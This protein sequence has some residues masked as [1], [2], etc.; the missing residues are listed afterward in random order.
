M[1]DFR[2]ESY[3]VRR[4]GNDVVYEDTQGVRVTGLALVRDEV[5]YARGRG[6]ARGHV[7]HCDRCGVPCH[8]D[9]LGCQS[10][11]MLCRD[12]CYDYDID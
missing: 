7:C 4:L 9:D 5:R 1:S 8:S 12:T 6:I 11:E 2:D 3:D 10:G